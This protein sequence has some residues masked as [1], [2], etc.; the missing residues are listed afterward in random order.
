MKLFRLFGFAIQPQRLVDPDAFADPPGGRLPVSATLRNALSRSLKTAESSG[1]MTQVVLN[2]DPDP[3]KGRTSPV[4]DAT[5]SLAF[6]EKKAAGAAALSLAQHLSRA[7]DDRSPECL[8][9]VAAYRDE[10]SA[11]RRVASWIFP[12]D[13]AF[14]FSPGDGSDQTDI[15]L[16]TDIF[17]RTSGLRKMALFSG[18]KIK[19]H[20]LTARVLDF[21][22][23][24]SDDV[25]GFWV[26]RFLDAQLAI[27]PVAGTKVLADGLRRA[28]EADLSIDEKR[29]VHAAA[30]AIY[31]MPKN[32]WSLEEV[33]DQ[34]LSGRGKEIFLDVA[35][36]EETRTSVFDLDRPTLEK[37][38]NVRNFRLPQGV[39]VSAPIQQ[40][41]D[42]KVVQI[43]EH[44]DE[45][46]NETI[47]RLRVEADVIQDRLSSRRV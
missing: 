21:Q 22:T 45:N 20:F 6:D 42:G 7:M 11:E 27:T 32:Q 43:D 18:K 13:E 37:R 17:S 34:F 12:Q 35:E 33:A 29:Q 1:R 24:R 30:L 25:A 38:L 39:W 40:V 46:G 10:G 36:N 47:E 31:T 15:E 3:D 19:S 44:R 23:G 8:F 14:R 5:I 28:S 16:L 9:L 26:E 2:V 41:G 4:R